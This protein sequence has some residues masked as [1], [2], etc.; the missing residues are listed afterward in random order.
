MEISESWG[1]IQALKT[2]RTRKMYDEKKEST[3][4]GLITT[5]R[6]EFR[7][8]VWPTRKELV[9]HTGTVIAVSLIFGAYIAIMDGAFG[10]LLGQIVRFIS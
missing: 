4:G 6:A 7:K 1:L 9:K 3:A 8:I 2:E 5:Y 10:A